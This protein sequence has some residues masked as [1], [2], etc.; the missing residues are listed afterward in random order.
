MV[1][2]TRAV[3]TS[4]RKYEGVQF[5]KG[6]SVEQYFA[7]LLFKNEPLIYRFDKIKESEK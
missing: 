5:G 6:N 3:L 2:V 7:K 1:S 4:Y